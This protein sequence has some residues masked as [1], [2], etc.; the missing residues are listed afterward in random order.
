MKPP[1]YVLSGP[2]ATGKTD[3]SLRFAQEHGC[4]IVCMDS[5]QIFRR[6]DIGT[7]KP[8]PQERALVPHHMV[9]VCE[10][11]ASFTVAQWTEMAEACF[12]DILA[13]GKTPLV[14]GGTGFYL[15]V[16]RHPMAMGMVQ[17]DPA[18]RS[19]LEAEAA[20]EGGRER[21]HSRLRQCD[22]ETADRLHPNDVRRVVRALE[23]CQLTGVPFSRQPQE[24]KEPPFDY[25]VAALTMDRAALYRRIN[26]RVEKMMAYGLMDE[27]RRLLEEG[28]SPQAQSMKGIGYKELVPVALEGADLGEAVALIQQN[29]RHYAKRQWTWLRQEEEVH[30]L[31]ALS[32]EAYSA[33]TDALLR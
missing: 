27:V 3:L 17:G 5:M 20:G 19:A 25:R 7:A 22:P 16:L 8:T 2:T 1:V 13:R 33:L 12:K 21:L 4:E 32:A 14:V 15:R 6:M 30:W 9:D 24:Q 18:L 28:V 23:V 26:E 11:E 10:P 31:D 29:T